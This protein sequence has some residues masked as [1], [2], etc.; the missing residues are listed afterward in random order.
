MCRPVV[1]IL[2]LACLPTAPV[3]SLLDSPREELLQLENARARYAEEMR[4]SESDHQAK[5]TA[6]REKHRQAAERGKAAAVKKGDLKLALAW[7]G[8]ENEIQGEGGPASSG[9]P[10]EASPR[11][12]EKAG[13]QHTREVADLEAESRRFQRALREKHRKIAEQGKVAATKTGDL[14]LAQAWEDFAKELEPRLV[15]LAHKAKVSVDT[16]TRENPKENMTDGDLTLSVDGWRYW[17]TGWVR[18][19]THWARFDLGS[20]RTIRKV[21]FLVPV[22]T[23]WHPNGHEPLE[24]DLILKLGGKVKERASV[25]GG[26]HPRSEPSKDGQ[27]QWILVEFKKEIEASEVEFQCHKTTGGN[28]GPVIFEFEILGEE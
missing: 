20:Q 17:F 23:R 8:L 13:A 2:A 14:K 15:N 5:L 27:T 18:A 16:Q 19:K 26:D 28:F 9:K 10:A 1:T 3:G 6:L 12:V 25:R 21:R 4:G 22:G 11:E 7:E 24:Y